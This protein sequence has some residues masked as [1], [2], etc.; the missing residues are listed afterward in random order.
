MY[1]EV[2]GSWFTRQ[3]K[4]GDDDVRDTIEGKTQHGQTTASD[5]QRRLPKSGLGRPVG[6]SQSMEGAMR[7]SASR[8]TKT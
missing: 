7:R 5:P 3:L 2:G 8:P 1:H 6:M 4:V